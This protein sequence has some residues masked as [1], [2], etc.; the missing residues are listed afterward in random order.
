MDFLVCEVWPSRDRPRVRLRHIG[1]PF[2]NLRKPAGVLDSGQIGEV[3][4]RNK[5]EIPA[6]SR[7]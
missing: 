6:N 3:K 2:G 5:V 4:R 7:L 1:T